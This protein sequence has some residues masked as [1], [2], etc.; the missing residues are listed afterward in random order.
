MCALVGWLVGPIMLRGGKEA[1]MTAIKRAW[2]AATISLNGLSLALLAA[3]CSSPDVPAYELVR[4]VRTMVVASGSD[5]H[6][7]VF[8]GKVDASR[9]VE[10]AFQVPGVLIDLPAKEGQKVAKGERI[11]QLRSD[12]FQA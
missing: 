4:P 8:P 6:T 5:S 1:G 2:A 3:G 12:E 7:R 10:L 11:A 9:R